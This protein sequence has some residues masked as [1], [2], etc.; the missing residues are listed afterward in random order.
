L[1]HTSEAATSA[2]VVRQWLFV[3]I[4]LPL[5][6][7]QAVQDVLGITNLA[8]GSD[9]LSSQLAS[10]LSSTPPHIDNYLK[11]PIWAV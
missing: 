7:L 10:T 6:T 2:V 5:L 9:I 8:T 4:I 11:A 3:I 1:N